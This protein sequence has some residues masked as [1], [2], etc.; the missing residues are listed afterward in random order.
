MPIKPEKRFE[1]GFKEEPEEKIETKEVVA[2]EKSDHEAEQSSIAHEYLQE[3]NHYK[4]MNEVYQARLRDLD[5]LREESHLP[6]V[7]D[8][9]S[10]V[11]QELQQISVLMEGSE[12][13]SEKLFDQLSEES[14]DKYLRG[15]EEMDEARKEA[16][17]AFEEG[18]KE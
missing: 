11:E 7:S 4:R 2:G 15:G 12:K 1:P 3:Q 5:G 17:R 14:R 9:I 8:N 10:R 16:E 6:G 13:Y 18:E